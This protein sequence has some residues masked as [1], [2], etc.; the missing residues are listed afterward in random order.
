MKGLKFRAIENPVH[1]ETYRALG[2]RAVPMAR[3]EVYSALKQGVLDGLDNALAFYESMGDYEVATYL[4][5]GVQLF[6]TPGALMISNTFFQRLPADLQKAVT[7]A[8]EESVPYQRKV[9][10]E[11][12]GEILARLKTKGVVTKEADPTPFAEASKSVWEK[13]S[14]DVG[15]AELI[16][17]VVDT[18]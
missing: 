15:G 4:T 17:A 3:P 2:A 8:A 5:L 16:Q 7:E 11:A 6:Q 14:A 10:R 9:F 18:K 13:F 12:E 1:L